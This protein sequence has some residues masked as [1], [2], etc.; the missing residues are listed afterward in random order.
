[1]EP[2][3]PILTLVSPSPPFSAL[4]SPRN[5]LKGAAESKKQPESGVS[6]RGGRHGRATGEKGTGSI[7]IGG[8]TSQKH[9]ETALRLL[10]FGEPFAVFFV[11]LHGA[12]QQRARRQRGHVPYVFG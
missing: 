10:L 9:V 5:K 11:D 6:Q 12:V 8:K 3:Q 1:M 7:V 4:F 2:F